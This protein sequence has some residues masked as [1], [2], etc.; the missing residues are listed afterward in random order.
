MIP[1]ITY[2]GATSS[3]CHSS[4]RR[5]NDGNLDGTRESQ[6]LIPLI[7]SK[8]EFIENK[9]A[10]EYQRISKV[11]DFKCDCPVCKSY[12]ILQIKELLRSTNKEDFYFA[13]ILIFIHALYQYDYIVS[14][15]NTNKNNY[16]DLLSNSPSTD[17]NHTYKTVLNHIK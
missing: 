1:L 6:I 15:C 7:N 13:K 2:F 12:S 14:F 17:I 5:A 16:L 3:D 9:K 10:W 11:I 4:W 8:L